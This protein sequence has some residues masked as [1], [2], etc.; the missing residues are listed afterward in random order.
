MSDL[1]ERVGVMTGGNANLIP[2]KGAL[3]V[4][5]GEQTVYL[6]AET[7]NDG[8]VLTLDSSAEE[9]MSWQPASP[10][11]SSF[12]LQRNFLDNEQY[13]NDGAFEVGASAYADFTDAAGGNLSMTVGGCGFFEGDFVDTAPKLQVYVGCASPASISGGT[14]VTEIDLTSTVATH[15]IESTDT[16]T[17]PAGSGFINVGVVG[18][19]ADSAPINGVIRALSVSIKT[20]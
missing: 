12:L 11:G 19:S 9:G 1:K 14:L 16:F 8:D 18:G 17:A 3:V 15:K 2:Y 5:D 6:M 4:G 13:A 10:G 20:V 7:G